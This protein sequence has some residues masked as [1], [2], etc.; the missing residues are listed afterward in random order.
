M[1]D[2][3]E[4]RR[5]GGPMIDR[6]LMIVEGVCAEKAREKAREESG[7]RTTLPTPLRL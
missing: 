3:V 6:G 7:M 2:K 1:R 5:I 4:Y